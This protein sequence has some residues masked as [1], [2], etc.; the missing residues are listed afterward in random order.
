[1]SDFDAEA[2][3]LLPLTPTVFHILLALSGG[4]RHG[5]WIMQE[6]QRLSDGRVGLGPGTLY[7]AIERI[8][9]SGLIEE[10]SAPDDQDPSARRRYYGLTP[11][12]TQTLLAESRRMED[13]VGRVK[14]RRLVP[15]G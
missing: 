2:Q 10:V 9:E 12:G 6:V 7:G 5:Y 15:D 14:A 11:L 8:V 1:M 13:L 4:A 3:A